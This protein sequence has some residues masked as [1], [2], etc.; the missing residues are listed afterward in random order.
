MVERR[1]ISDWNLISNNQINTICRLFIQIWES[2]HIH[3]ITHSIRSDKLEST[4]FSYVRANCMWGPTLSC[5][6]LYQWD[7]KSAPTLPSTHTPTHLIHLYTA[8]IARI[9][10]NIIFSISAFPCW[11]RKGVFWC[12]I[13]TPNVNGLLFLPVGMVFF[14]CRCS[15]YSKSIKPFSQSFKDSCH[16]DF[17]W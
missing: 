15:C 4:R 17:A 8:L 11:R 1:P 9:W 12:P 2:P 14:S 10:Y 5:L 3:Y 13:L 6:R 16:K 7:Y